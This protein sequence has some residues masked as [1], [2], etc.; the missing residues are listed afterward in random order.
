M[1]K[2]KHSLR[3]TQSA[4]NASAALSM[5]MTLDNLP[6]KDAKFYRE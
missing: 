3:G 5:E 1:L 6:L 4:M 2:A